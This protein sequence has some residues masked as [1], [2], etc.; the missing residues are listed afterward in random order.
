MIDNPVKFVPNL[1]Y[2]NDKAVIKT[3][4][5]F[6]KIK[7]GRVYSNVFNNHTELNYTIKQ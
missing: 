6:R 7:V 1:C 3:K 4:M 5:D 2:L